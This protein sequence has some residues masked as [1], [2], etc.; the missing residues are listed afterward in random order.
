MKGGGLKF[1]IICE[2]DPS[3]G[4]AK[5]KYKENAGM[6]SPWLFMGVDNTKDNKKQGWYDENEHVA[7]L[8]AND[9]RSG[10]ILR[11]VYDETNQ[12]ENATQDLWVKEFK[13]GTKISYDRDSH[14]MKIEGQDLEIEVNCKTLAIT[15]TDDDVSIDSNVSITGDLS[16]SGNLDVTGDISGNNISANGNMDAN[17]NV[18]AQ[19]D[20]KAG[21]GV[22]SLIGHKHAVTSA[23]GV[24][25]P[26]IP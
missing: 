23:P 22:I 18:S 11:A 19:G 5:I 7:V 2:V 14:Q 15:S 20:V 17:G 26:S 12:P 9:M 25:G 16:V 3:K 10:I 24:T 1:G 21:G 4:M 8:M 6:V 13:D